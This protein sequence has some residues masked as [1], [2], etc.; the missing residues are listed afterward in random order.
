MPAAQALE[1]FG[2]KWRQPFGT[3]AVQR[4]P[5]RAQQCHLGRP[6]AW[7]ST[8][9]IAD[10]LLNWRVAQQHKCVLARVARDGTELAQELAFLASAGMDVAR[11]QCPRQVVPTGLLHRLIVIASG[12]ICCEA[13]LP[14]P[15]RQ[16]FEATREL[17]QPCGL[18]TCPR[19]ATTTTTAPS[20]RFT[21]TDLRH[22]RANGGLMVVAID[23]PTARGD[24]QLAAVQPLHY[25]CAARSGHLLFDEPFTQF[26][27]HGLQVKDS[28]KMSNAA[29]RRQS[30]RVFRPQGADTLRMYQVFIGPC[31][32][33]GEWS[34]RASAE[35]DGPG[36]GVGPRGPGVRSTRTR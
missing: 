28:G 11:R 5:T 35:S 4:R 25:P 23:W 9:A 2:Q 10:T 21:Y 30:G 34:D 7:R 20:L 8:P 6:V 33:G 3:D 12:R 16:N 27:A 32:R 24:R 17:A 31:E 14:L 15:G 19:P 1:Q 22:I 29:A 18:R 36:A 26:R 13:D